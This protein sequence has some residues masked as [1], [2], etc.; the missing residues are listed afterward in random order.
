MQNIE[1][2]KDITNFISNQYRPRWQSLNNNWKEYLLQRWEDCSNIKES[3]LR[4]K[5][6][7]LEIP[8]CPICGNNCKFYGSINYVYDNT[9][10]NRK[11]ITKLRNLNSKQTK[12]ERYG[13]ENYNNMKKTKQTKLERY[14]DENYNNSIEAA[15]H[16]NY[17]EIQE[18]IKNTCLE[19]YGVS[20]TWKIDGV[21]E[22]SKQTKLEKYGDENFTNREKY[23]E[24][25][26]TRY[27]VDNSFKYEKFQQKY[28]QTCLKRYNVDHNWKM[29]SEHK[30]TNTPEANNKK[31]QTSLKN[32]NTEYPIQSK[33]VQD[34]INETKRKNHT[35]NTSKIETES[36]KLLKEKYQDVLYQYKSDKYPFVCDFYIPSLDLYI[37]CNYHWTHGGKPYEGTEEDINKI[38]LWESRNTKFYNNAI[39]CW[40]VRDV[41]KRNIAKE[42]NLN[43]LEFWD[44]NK[45]KKWL[46]N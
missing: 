39:N 32:W 12:L 5:Y 33:A 11:C 14:G 31:K 2:E 35:F 38:K 42:N 3:Y 36:Y 27:G 1:I 28:K 15:K 16:K 45:L 18:K 20:S 9:C 13:D 17:K 24:T 22:K 40:T 19:R 43:Y 44:I 8:K 7:I 41:K 46:D 30:L 6:N 21:L 34:K 29:A 10:G 25:C 26:I 23:K 37:E 4:I